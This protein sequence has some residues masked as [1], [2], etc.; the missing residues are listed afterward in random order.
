MPGNAAIAS[1][2]YFRFNPDSSPLKPA[3]GSVVRVFTL[4]GRVT[5]R[6]EKLALIVVLGSA[7][8]IDSVMFRSSLRA[9]DSVVVLWILRLRSGDPFPEAK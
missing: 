8:L 7:V 2:S 5:A 9:R 4:A 1:S 3:G 6:L